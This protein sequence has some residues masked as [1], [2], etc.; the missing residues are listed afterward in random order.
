MPAYTVLTRALDTDDGMQS[1]ARIL[2]R[3]PTQRPD[4][5]E[6]MADPFTTGQNVPQRLK[7][8]VD[9]TSPSVPRDPPLG[10]L[11]APPGKQLQMA[12]STHNNRYST[13]RSS[14]R[15]GVG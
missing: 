5:F 15:T 1:L 9:G 12:R 4:A 13:C 8:I 11:G 2:V 7:A 3:D 10:A 14:R 6:L